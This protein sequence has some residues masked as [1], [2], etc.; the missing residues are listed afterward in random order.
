MVFG[1]NSLAGLIVAIVVAYLAFKI[2]KH[3]AGAVVLL[4]FLLLILQY[5]GYL[6]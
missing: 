6:L 5:F 2:F 3:L 4:V 1:I